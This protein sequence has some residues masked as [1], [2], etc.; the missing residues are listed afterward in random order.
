MQAELVSLLP[1]LRRFSLGLTGA[2]DLADDL[3]Q[4]GCLKALERVEQYKE[5]T[6]LASWMFKILQNTWFDQQRTQNRRNTFPDSD[7]IEQ[8]VG[9][10][11]IRVHENQDTLRRV[12][13][14]IEHLP[15]EQRVV[16]LL[17]CVEG[18]PYKEV[19]AVLDI[20]VG[21]VMSRLARA[22]GRLADALEVNEEVSQ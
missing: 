7:A 3:V 6:S 16:L 19:S 2:A 13:D 20:P 4:I 12:Q 11:G 9:E 21:T 8:H 15:D 22:R 14:L 10:D 5:G 17:V 18:L 1:R